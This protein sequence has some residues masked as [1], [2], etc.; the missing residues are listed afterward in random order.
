MELVALLNVLVL[1]LIIGLLLVIE[2]EG[3]RVGK[4]PVPVRIRRRK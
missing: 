4:V 3:K 1:S 2:K